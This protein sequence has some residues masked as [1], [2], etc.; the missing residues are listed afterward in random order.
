MDFKLASDS[1]AELVFVNPGHAD[2]LERIVYRRPGTGQL[3]AR[4]EGE[5]GGKPFSVDYVYLASA[6]GCA[7]VKSA[8]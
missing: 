8:K 3:T 2:H 7:S 6:G 1:G 5:D 4:I